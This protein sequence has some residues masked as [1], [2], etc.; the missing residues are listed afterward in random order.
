[1]R[2]IRQRL[3]LWQIGAVVLTAVLVSFITYRV[4][5]SGFN[6]IRDYGLQQIAYSVVRHGV[7]P[8]GTASLPA[9]PPEADVS[10]AL[11][12]IEPSDEIVP[13]EDLGQFVSQIWSADR[14]LQYSSL[15]EGGPPLQAVGL[16]G[17]RWND[18]DWR[19]YTVIDRQQT[20]QVAV[21]TADRAAS[22]SELVPWLL[23][24]LG[25]LVVLLSLL[26]HTAVE[27]ALAPIDTWGKDLRRRDARQL[28]AVT[29]DALPEE[30]EPLGD[31]LNALL[32]RVQQLL[33]SQRVLLA[34]VA[35]ELNT[36]LAAIKLQAQLA[37]R[38]NETEQQRQAALDELDRG[39]ARA[40]HLVAQLLQM[41]RLEPGVREPQAV[42]VRLD[43]LAAESVAGLSAQADERAIDLGVSH[44]EAVTVVADPDDLRVVFDNLI[45]NALRHTPEGAR[46]D[47]EVSRDGQTAW[48]S[49]ADDGPGIAPE[50]RS[51][52]LQR[53][54]RLRPEQTTG[55]GLG[56]A[57][58]AQ[59][60]QLHGG[61]VD[62]DGRAG[63][64]LRVRVGL[65]VHESAA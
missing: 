56:L 33:D 2:S 27:R 3:L 30:L 23:A 1:M 47:V 11:P 25:L 36:P 35:H 58:V 10:P 38:S 62:M 7:R 65:P 64:G 18:E 55:S 50:D 20:V 5:W 43:R 46:V 49:V 28:H 39:I 57:I 40:T 42:P 19:V 26:I 8:M 37:R 61:Q 17:V 51:R 6:R 12:A 52:A 60:A 54:V 13:T 59:I 4:A 9:Q 63:G 45:D 48:L 32:A 41:A 31:A 53:F 22:F 21:T 29:T 44:S 24:P 16:H 15:A 34:D 14:Q